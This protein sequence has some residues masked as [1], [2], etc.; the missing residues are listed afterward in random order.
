MM[1]RLSD[2]LTPRRTLIAI[3]VMAAALPSAK[4]QEQVD[5]LRTQPAVGTPEQILEALT[6]AQRLGMTYAIAYF[7]DA[8]YDT[9]GIELFEQQVIPELVTSRSANA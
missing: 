2:I 1:D 8:A 3:F 5:G 6:T 4:A 9:S 7:A